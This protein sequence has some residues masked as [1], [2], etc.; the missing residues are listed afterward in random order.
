MIVI[1]LTLMVGSV[2]KSVL[3]VKKGIIQGSVN[4]SDNNLIPL[5]DNGFQNYYDHIVLSP[6]ISCDGVY[7]YDCLQ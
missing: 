2:Q 3:A 5:H 4:I 1:G 6:D 7:S